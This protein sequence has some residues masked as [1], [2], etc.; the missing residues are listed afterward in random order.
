MH[1]PARLGDWDRH[2]ASG[3]EARG[4]SGNGCQ[5]R[6]RQDGQ[7]A[8]A[9]Q[10]FNDDVDVDLVAKA[11]A[12]GASE[13]LPAEAQCL[14]FV[15]GHLGETHP[16]ID[17]LGAVDRRIVDRRLAWRRIDFAH[18]LGIYSFLDPSPS[19]PPGLTFATYA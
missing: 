14:Q 4:L 18:V 5:V 1:H 12:A 19:A 16:D 11:E 8:I 15:A 2:F 10:R 17:L 9:L 6:L 3:Q 7:D 13:D